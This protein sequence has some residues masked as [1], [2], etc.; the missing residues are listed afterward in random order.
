MFAEVCN[1][2]VDGAD[3]CLL[4]EAPTA[5]T[6]LNIHFVSFSTFFHVLNAMFTYAD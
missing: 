5:Q 1:A 4:I 3:A 2:T 6:H